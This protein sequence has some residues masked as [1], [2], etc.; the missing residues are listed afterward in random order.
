MVVLQNK[1]RTNYKSSPFFI[2]IVGVVFF[3]F[4]G[5]ASQKFGAKVVAVACL[6]PLLETAVGGTNSL[7]HFSNSHH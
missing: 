7:I 3:L 1:W 4:P 5:V 6:S 2:I